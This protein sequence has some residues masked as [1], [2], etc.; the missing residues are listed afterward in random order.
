MIAIFLDFAG[1]LDDH[2]LLAAAVLSDGNGR[3]QNN[4]V[5]SLLTTTGKGRYTPFSAHPNRI[6]HVRRS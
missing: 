6:D 5:I 4:H 1:I 3:Q 2:L